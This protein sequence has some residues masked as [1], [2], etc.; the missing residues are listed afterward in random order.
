M[1][2]VVKS[3]AGVEERTEGGFVSMETGV[4]PPEDVAE[5]LIARALAN[6]MTSYL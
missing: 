6:D 2:K 5:G 4:V 3:T 1:D